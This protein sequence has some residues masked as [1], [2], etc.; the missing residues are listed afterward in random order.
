MGL[1]AD[2]DLWEQAWIAVKKRGTGNQSFRKVKGHATDKDVEKG[3]STIKDREGN[4]KS[5]KLADK[6]VEEI[7]GRG[8]VKLG[9]WCEA[10]Q[11]D[12]RKLLVRVQ[13]MIVG[14]TL[15]EKE[16]RANDRTIQKALLRYDPE[17]WVKTD[18][19]IRGE[20]QMKVE[21]QSIQIIQPTKGKHRFAH[22]Q[23]L[24]EEVH[25]F[26]MKRKWAPAQV[27]TE[28][29]GV[30]WM[31]MFA[32]Y[33]TTGN[34]SEQGQHQKNPEATNRAEQRRLKARCAKDKKLNLNETTVVAKPSL[35]E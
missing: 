26:L 33:D 32:L 1:Q 25:A 14:V 10:R 34:R 18:A 31:E 15:A 9:K 4:D 22:C 11:K 28:V 30:T 19:E 12:Y 23:V 13:T 16:E 8:L 20:E 5:D 3:I 24:Y 7:A 17:K 27:D 35:D 21:H 6:G 2:G 29:A